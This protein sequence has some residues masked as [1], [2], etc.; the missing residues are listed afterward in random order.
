MRGGVRK[1]RGQLLS[2]LSPHFESGPLCGFGCHV[3]SLG[4]GV[5][6]CKIRQISAMLPASP[7]VT[8]TGQCFT[9]C[10]VPEGKSYLLQM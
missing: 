5:L 9:N 1:R 8:V 2:F 4:I 3:T 7:T 10:R 6:F